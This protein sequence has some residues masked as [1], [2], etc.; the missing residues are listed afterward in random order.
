MTPRLFVALDPEAGDRGLLDAAGARHLRALHLRPGDRFHAIV[1]AGCEREAF[2]DRVSAAG[3]SCRLSARLPDRGA[4]PTCPRVL[5]I[6]LA[7]LARLDLVVEKA[8]ELG[9]TAIEP[10]CAERSQ[11]RAVS[12]ARLER[13]RRIA[14][15]ACEQCGRTV[16]PTVAPPS[17]FASL[18]S[19]TSAATLL[20]APGADPEPPASARSAASVGSTLVVGPEGGLTNEEVAALVERGAV[21]IGLGPRILRFETAAIAALA[22]IATWAGARPPGFRREPLE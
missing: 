17:S 11:V 9:A 22:T 3:A 16:A 2:L 14:R 5:A 20:F 6:G 7:D 8:T 12:P 10:F 19:A 1:G 21:A 15:S 13:W 4:D 18:L